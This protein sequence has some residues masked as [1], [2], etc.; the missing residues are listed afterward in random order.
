MPF[1]AK[2]SPLIF[3]KLMRVVLRYIREKWKI[4]WIG[5]M[6]DLLFLHEDRAEL[7]HVTMEIAKYLEWLSWILSVDKCEFSPKQE[8]CFLGWIW[9]FKEMNVRMKKGRREDLIKLLEGW[10]MKCEKAEVVGN[11]ELA[12]LLGKVNFL[13]TQFPRMSLYTM[14]LNR[15]KVRGVKRSGW[16]GRTR[17]TGQQLGELR[18]IRR[19]VKMNMPY[20]IVMRTIDATLT[21]DAC[22]QG[23]GAIFVKGGCTSLYHGNFEKWK[24]PLTSSNQ[25]ETAAILLALR[26]I[27]VELEVK[28]V[29]CLCV[30]SD[31]ST[32]VSNLARKRAARSMLHLVRR[33]FVILEKLNI[34]VMAKHRPGVQNV[35]A[36]ALSRLEGA[37]DY[38]LRKEVFQKG[39]QDLKMDSE[40][41]MD[42][43]EIDMFA[44]G[45]NARLMKYVSPSPEEGAVASD[46]FSQNWK[47]QRVYAHPPILLIAK[48]ILKVELEKVETVLVVPNWT[49][50]AWWPRLE[51]IATKAVRLGKSEEVLIE[52]EIMKKKGTKLPPG[53]MYMC[54]ISWKR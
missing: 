53:E 41:E 43:V 10:I 22:Q 19:W 49:S 30:E 52:G 45:R 20:S 18:T 28:K 25:R 50:Q 36:D 29:Q 42:V 4:R 37:G 16:N 13:R 48:T 24:F 15:A 33:I 11:R 47:S 21:T 14:E 26:E 35:T 39:I 40:T 44:T 46:A 5:Y 9:D 51:R 1:G 31:N 17:L 8:I 12:A 6:D 2:H 54:R 23:W 38:Y 27:R 7:E 3:T 32:T 34:Q